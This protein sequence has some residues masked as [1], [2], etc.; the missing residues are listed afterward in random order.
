MLEIW[1]NPAC[2]RSRATLEILRSAEAAGAVLGGDSSSGER[3]AEDDLYRVRRYLEDPPGI[4]ELDATLRALGCD[5]RG[6]TRLNEP[7]ARAL[8]LAERNLDRGEWLQILVDNG[9]AIMG[10]PPDSVRELL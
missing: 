2:S 3:A 9:R 7:I 4:A 8:R 10:R 6:I 1:H 5:P